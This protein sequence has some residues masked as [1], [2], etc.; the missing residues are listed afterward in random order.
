MNLRKFANPE[1]YR[2]SGYWARQS[3]SLIMILIMVSFMLGIVPCVGN[4]YIGGILLCGGISR[5]YCKQIIL[6]ILEIKNTMLTELLVS[7]VM[8]VDLWLAD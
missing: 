8:V 5:E 2:I 6:V 3:L 4:E 1:K 7:N